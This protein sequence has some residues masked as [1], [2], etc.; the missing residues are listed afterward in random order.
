MSA[1]KSGISDT[2]LAKNHSENRNNTC[3]AKNVRLS[4]DR[5][6]EVILRKKGYPTNR[7][8][9]I[10]E[11]GKKS[12]RAIAI[13]SLGSPLLSVAIV[14]KI[15]T[16]KKTA[17]QKMVRSRVVPMGAFNNL[18]CQVE[19]FIFLSCTSICNKWRVLH[20][21]S[22]FFFLLRKFVR[23]KKCPPQIYGNVVERLLLLSQAQIRS[24]F[25]R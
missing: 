13:Y 14:K 22:Q 9:L 17:A 11:S 25:L 2:L 16:C 20:H 3:W 12:V 23:N 21:A 4:K 19:F 10:G 8:G 18:P 6:S 24:D 15:M 1:L 5:F 7:L